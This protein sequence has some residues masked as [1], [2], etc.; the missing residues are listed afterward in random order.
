MSSERGRLV[1]IS[2]PTASGKSTLWRR[3]V[4]LP[5]VCFSVSA[6]TRAAREGEVD[7]RDYHFLSAAEFERRLAAGE[8]LEH[9]VV[10]GQ[11]YGTLRA[12]VERALQAGNDLLLEIDVQGAE[13]V[14]RS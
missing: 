5:R 3:L 9:A 7:G 12:E 8:F 2:G 14:R 13:Q 11:R 1:V 4:E 6:T 10:H